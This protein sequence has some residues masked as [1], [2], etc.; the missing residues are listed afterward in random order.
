MLASYLLYCK[1]TTV[2]DHP[3][4]CAYSEFYINI[5]II[6]SIC[7]CHNF[8]RIEQIL[9]T[10]SNKVPYTLLCVVRDLINK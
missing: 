3:R 10:S 2:N 6:V 4:Y 7:Q 1:Y 9:F 5:V 8:M